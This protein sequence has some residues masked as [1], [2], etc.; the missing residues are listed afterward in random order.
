M[1]NAKIPLHDANLEDIV[2]GS[3]LLEKQAFKRCSILKARDFYYEQNQLIYAAFEAVY[4]R[5]EPIDLITIRQEL[6]KTKSLETIGGVARLAKLT[7]LVASTANIENH[8]AILTQ[9]SVARQAAT[10]LGENIG[11]FYDKGGDHLQ[12]VLTISQKLRDLMAFDGSMSVSLPQ[13]VE[14]GL[15]DLANIGERILSGISLLDKIMRFYGGTSNLI[16]ARPAGGKSDLM[17]NLARNIAKQGHNVLIISLEMQTIELVKRIMSAEMGINNKDFETID[18]TVRIIEKHSG[19]IM[20]LPIWILDKAK[21]RPMDIDVEISRLDSLGYKPHA[22]FID[23]VQLM[24][25]DEKTQIREQAIASI[26][27]TLKGLAKEHNI[28][29]FPLAQLG[30]DAQGIEPNMSHL[31]E[32][33]ALEQDADSII[34]PMADFDNNQMKIKI[35]KNRHGKVGIIE[36]LNYEPQFSRITDPFVSTQSHVMDN[37]DIPFGGGS[38]L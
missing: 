2:L 27:R 8:A 25:S 5:K 31:R 17:L 35:E 21:V 14:S 20:G 26:S 32:S 28:P 18:K 10:I 22:V 38:D 19:G 30:R 33:G 11:E 1:T 13:A 9:L 16:A 36:N 12:A 15:N 23:Y 24:Y 34:F 3:I 37:S 7:N 29:F 4:K 6:I